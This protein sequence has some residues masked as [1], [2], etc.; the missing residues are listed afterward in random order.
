MAGPVSERT[1]TGVWGVHVTGGWPGCFSADP[2]SP[3]TAGG[4]EGEAGG[5]SVRADGESTLPSWVHY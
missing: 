3:W 4:E 2:G 1:G 5:V